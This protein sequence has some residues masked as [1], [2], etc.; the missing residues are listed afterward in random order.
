MRSP[1]ADRV[2]VEGHL[3]VRSPKDCEVP[4]NELDIEGWQLSGSKAAASLRR[5]PGAR[6]MGNWRL[7]LNR[8]SR[9]A[10]PSEWDDKKFRRPVALRV[11]S[12]RPLEHRGHHRVYRRVIGAQSS[13]NRDTSDGNP[14]TAR[15]HLARPGRLEHPTS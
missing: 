15:V 12:P 14:A 4:A 2:V 10:G 8:R 11:R 3:H 13:S 1:F 6:G 5:S 7:G 9:Q